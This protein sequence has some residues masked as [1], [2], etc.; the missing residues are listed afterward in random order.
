[1]LA[2]DCDEGVCKY[3]KLQ[4]DM[5]VVGCSLLEGE[6]DV[7]NDWAGVGDEHGKYGAGGC[8]EDIGH[9]GF[10]VVVRCEELRVTVMDIIVR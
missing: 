9:C 7:R 4:N 5:V 3:H 2:F 8:L 10:L 1:M 6:P